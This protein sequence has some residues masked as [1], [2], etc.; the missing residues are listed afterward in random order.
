MLGETVAVFPDAFIFLP[1]EHVMGVV[2]RIV[3]F[4]PLPETVTVGPV[5]PPLEAPPLPTPLM[6]PVAAL[7]ASLAIEFSIDV[8]NALNSPTIS[9]AAVTNFEPLSTEELKTWPVTWPGLLSLGSVPSAQKPLLNTRIAGYAPPFGV[10]HCP[11][12]RL[13]PDLQVE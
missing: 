5:P 8:K 11:P 1:V 3:V 4:V 10:K 6:A 9:F 2:A 12:A 13:S 7:I